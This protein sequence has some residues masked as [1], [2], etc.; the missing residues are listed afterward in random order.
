MINEEEAQ[1][2]ASRYIEEDEAIAGMPRLKEINESLV[3]YIVPI[4]INNIIVGEIHIN[5]ETGEN[6]GGSGC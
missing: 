6:L 4:L 5:S 3:V 1:L 2:I